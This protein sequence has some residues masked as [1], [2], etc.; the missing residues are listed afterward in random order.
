MLRDGIR[1]LGSRKDKSLGILDGE[2]GHKTQEW[3]RE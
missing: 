3:L 2:V 1:K